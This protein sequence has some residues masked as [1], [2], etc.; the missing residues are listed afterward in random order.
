MRRLSLL[1]LVVPLALLAA[2]CGGGG[3]GSSVSKDDVA[4]V[5]GEHITRSDLD[6]RLAQAGCSYKLQKKVFPK[7]GSAEYQSIQQQ[8]LAS[9]VQR[10][11][12]TQKA[13]GLGATV[14]D[15]QVEDQLKQLKKQYFGNSEKRYQTELKRQCVTD[16]E[17]RTDIRANLLSDA[18]FKK[19]TAGIAVTDADAKDYYIANAPQYSQPQTREVRH[20]LVKDKATAD[21]LYAQLKGG[22]DFATLA[23][24]YSIDPGS[25]SQ[26]GKLTIQRGQTVPQF[27]KVAFE[28]KTGELSK[29]VKS[30]FGW[31]IIQALKPATP[32]KATPFAQ[33]KEAIKQQLLQQK[34]SAA[35][36]TWL[37]G[38]KKEYASKT[39]YATGLAPPVETAGTTTG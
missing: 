36:T 2:S 35:L 26:G 10:V 1:L 4:V 39:S 3:G 21:K 30:Q 9:L 23:K 37:A 31:H 32:R 24:K 8:I 5:G 17:V 19:V 11:E 22:A 25:K 38:V 18:V 15:K 34:R 16:P 29:P 20:I 7:A 33:V 14:T 12:V 28:L 13:P 27:D 6:R